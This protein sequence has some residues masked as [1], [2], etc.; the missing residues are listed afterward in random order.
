M[1]NQNIWEEWEVKKA[2]QMVEV[3]NFMLY[4]QPMATAT[5][6]HKPSRESFLCNSTVRT[7]FPASPAGLQ[8]LTCSRLF[9]ELR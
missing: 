4:Q 7:I 5:K 2:V 1:K 6:Y 3:I 9:A 8:P